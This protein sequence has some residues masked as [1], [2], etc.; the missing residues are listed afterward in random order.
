MKYEKRTDWRYRHELTDGEI[1]ATESVMSPVF[2]V[3]FLIDTI[4]GLHADIICLQEADLQI[5]SKYRHILDN[6]FASTFSV[7]VK[8][9]QLV[10]MWNKHLYNSSYLLS[11]PLGS[12]LDESRIVMWVKNQ[13]YEQL[14]ESFNY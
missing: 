2:R 7:R 3:P 5:L 6:R 8:H 9:C 12:N 11:V 13:Q 14:S 10:T 4:L 1:K